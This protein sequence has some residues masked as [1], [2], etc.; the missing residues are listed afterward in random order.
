[1]YID[2]ER[3]MKSIKVDD[4][5]ILL[6]E[7]HEYECY[8][9]KIKIKQIN[10]FYKWNKFSK[11]LGVFLQFYSNV[12]DNFKL[13]DKVTDLKK[14]QKNIRITL[15]NE[16]WG[17]YAFKVLMKLC[18]HCTGLN[19]RWMKKMFTIDDWI[20]LFCKIY[21]YNVMGVK[22]NLSNVLKIISKVQS[23]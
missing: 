5:Q 22:K 14:F 15:K 12:C 6:N 21:L 19:K 11:W 9:K 1:M 17:R 2:I 18:K 7:P 8:G 10:W 4:D 13:P 3:L 23:N 20:I 16:V